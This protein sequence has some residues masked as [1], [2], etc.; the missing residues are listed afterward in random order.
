MEKPPSTGLPAR[1]RI[2]VRD[3]QPASRWAA[4][5][6]WRRE[7]IAAGE[8][9]AGSVADDQPVMVD[10]TDPDAVIDLRTEGDE[11]GP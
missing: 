5:S 4:F 9:V 3:P 1:K 10:L 11:R 7:R 6:A 2:V 8:A